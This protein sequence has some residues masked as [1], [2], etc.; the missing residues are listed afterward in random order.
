MFVFVLLSTTIPLEVI[1]SFVENGTKFI[2]AG[3]KSNTAIKENNI[4]IDIEIPDHLDFL[5]SLAYV[6]V[7]I[8]RHEYSKRINIRYVAVFGPEYSCTDEVVSSKIVELSASSTNNELW[9][10]QKN[11]MYTVLNFFFC[12]ASVFRQLAQAY[13]SVIKIHNSEPHDKNG[14]RAKLLTFISQTR[15]L[16]KKA[17]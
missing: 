9:T 7:K 5:K 12:F 16:V 11:G 10:N 14:A 4:K 3:K 13:K 6:D 15:C 1:Q 8:I 17:N 2:V